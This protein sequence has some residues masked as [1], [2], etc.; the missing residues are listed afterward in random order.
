MTQYSQ[1]RI[2]NCFFRPICLELKILF[3]NENSQD[4]H[5]KGM[6]NKHFN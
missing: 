4:K 6:S 3:R 5:I 1:N 2:E